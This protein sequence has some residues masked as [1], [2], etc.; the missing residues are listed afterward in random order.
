M[1]R[2]DERRNDCGRQALLFFAAAIAHGAFAYGMVKVPYVFGDEAGYLLKAAALAGHVT[3]GYSSYFPAYALLLV[4]ALLLGGNPLQSFAQ[5]QATNAVLA[6]IAAVLMYRIARRFSANRSSRHATIAAATV[7]AYP[8]FLAFG[9]FALSE[10]L[11]IPLTLALGLAVMRHADLRTKESA[12]R[13]GVLCGVLALTHPK[14][15]VVDAAA[16]LAVLPAIWRQRRYADGCLILAVAACV[17]V[18]PYLLA[19]AFFRERLGQLANGVSG[20]YPDTT[21]ILQSVAALFSPKGVRELGDNLLGQ[22]FYLFAGSLGTVVVGALALFGRLSPRPATSVDHRKSM[23]GL[24]PA[25]TGLRGFAI[26]SLLTCAATMLMTAWFMHGGERVDQLFYGRYDE[27]VIA[28]LMLPAL[29]TRT[30]PRDWIIAAS[31]VLIAGG[32]SVSI[33]GI[34]LHGWLVEINM[35][36]LQL[37]RVLLPDAIGNTGLHLAIVTLMATALLIG[38]AAMARYR[39]P[40][41]AVMGLFLFAALMAGLD[42]LHPTSDLHAAQHSIADYVKRH[43]PAV[44]CVNYDVD[45][46]DYWGRYNYQYFLLPLRQHQWSMQ[47]RTLNAG[48]G[49]EASSRCSDFVISSDPDFQSTRPG[50]TMLLNEAQS[51]Q[52]LWYAPRH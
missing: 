3:D 26:F 9:C 34:S 42:Y 48:S 38:L 18:P 39:S 2:E 13:I 24:D 12:I 36:G 35:I 29:A 17:F 52:V 11:F 51:T 32:L 22:A 46:G 40:R 47:N 37:W 23:E 44:N 16:A 19:D 6:G 20:H 30:R 15:I 31:S 49:D 28:L 7:S 41:P 45:H 25:E 33:H 21:G 27:G 43:Y 8:S 14:G 5:V 4:P 1:R 10:N 50:A